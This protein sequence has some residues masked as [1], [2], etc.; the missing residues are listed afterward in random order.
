MSFRSLLRLLPVF[1]AVALSACATKPQGF[2]KV[3]IYR[4]NPEA[5]ITA[6][7][8]S[9]PFEHEHLLYGAVSRD[10][11]EARRGNYY[12]FF[13][14]VDDKSQP[15]KVRFEYRQAVTRS[16]VKQ[17]ELEIANVKGSNITKFQITGNEFQTAGKVLAW[18]AVLLQGGKE[19][20]TTRSSMWN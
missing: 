7:D 9:I 1:A 6:V 19:I 13:W 8:P 17:Q 3:K 16:A 14:K 2:T 15:V 12:T 10:D 18:R 5:K 11:R 20:A 4:L